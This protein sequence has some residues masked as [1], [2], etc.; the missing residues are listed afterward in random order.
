MAT[1]IQEDEE[2]P[3]SYPAKPWGLSDAAVALD[4]ATIWARI[5][6]FIAW[7]WTARGVTWI[8][9]GPGEWIAPLKPAEV[10]T[11]HVWNNEAWETMTLP[12]SP[13]GGYD[14]PGCGPYKI[15]ATIGDAVTVPA[16]VNEAYKRLAD[17]YGNATTNAGVRQETVD[18]IG[19]TEYDLS[20]IA[21]AMN[22]SGAGDLL[23][24]F[25]RVL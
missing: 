14:L 25:R 1:T 12:A 16:I 6:A 15:V 23:R 7:R 13:R 18:G 5:E 19:S 4:A 17:F 10:L 2:I 8:V 11:T 9:E 20:A 24:S 21:S 3:G 22:R